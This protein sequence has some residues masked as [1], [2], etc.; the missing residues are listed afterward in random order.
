MLQNQ[1]NL[2]LI[3]QS[4]Y[5]GIQSRRSI[6]HNTLLLYYDHNN[7]NSCGMES[8]LYLPKLTIFVNYRQKLRLISQQQFGSLSRYRKRRIADVVIELLQQMRNDNNYNASDALKLTDMLCHLNDWSVVHFNRLCELL[9]MY[10][11]ANTSGVVLQKLIQ[12]ADSV[13]KAQ[14]T[15][16]LSVYALQLLSLNF[17]DIPSFIDWPMLLQNLSKYIHIHQRELKDADKVV[18]NIQSLFMNKKLIYTQGTTDGVIAILSHIIHTCYK[19]SDTIPDFMEVEDELH[20]KFE[21]L[22]EQSKVQPILNEIFLYNLAI[23]SAPQHISK[24]ADLLAYYTHVSKYSNLVIKLA[25]N[26]KF[27]DTLVRNKERQQSLTLSTLFGQVLSFADVAL[28]YPKH[29]IVQIVRTL[30]HRLQSGYQQNAVNSNQVYEFLSFYHTVMFYNLLYTKNIVPAELFEFDDFNNTNLSYTNLVL[31]YSPQAIP[32]LMRYQRFSDSIQVAEDQAAFNI[33][34]MINGRTP[35][36][37][38]ITIR[39]SHLMEDAVNFLSIDDLASQVPLKIS[40][41]NQFGKLQNK[42][43]VM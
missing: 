21:C 36:Q 19:I 43:A 16:D 11:N 41:V 7:A 37:H 23:N 32:F 26:S 3:L 10:A 29:D 39:R 5:R 9:T 4:R 6:V 8:L 18:D 15:D 33:E 30:K 22:S 40:L 38:N 20:D 2:A 25:F 17:L 1:I 14:G 42:R 28:V 35:L 12:L 27:V 24:A 34:D 13:Y 31:K